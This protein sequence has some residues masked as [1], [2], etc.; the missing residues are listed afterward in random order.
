MLFLHFKRRSFKRGRQAPADVA[1]AGAWQR[2]EIFDRFTFRPQCM[3]AHACW[4]AFLF[5]VGADC[6]R[7]TPGKSFIVQPLIV[8]A[9]FVFTV[10]D[11]ANEAAAAAQSSVDAGDSAAQGRTST[12]RKH[13]EGESFLLQPWAAIERKRKNNNKKTGCRHLILGTA[14]GRDGV[15]GVVAERSSKTQQQQQQTTPQLSFN[16]VGK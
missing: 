13:L 3:L 14:K 5:T 10:W 16:S 6:C 4:R 11:P 12:A 1:S 15:L 8:C 9:K 7:Q 2:P